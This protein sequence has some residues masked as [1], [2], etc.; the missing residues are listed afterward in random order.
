MKFIYSLVLLLFFHSSHAETYYISTTGNDVTGSGSV[1]NP[2]RSLYKAASAVTV[3]GSI[4]HV[5]AGIYIETQQTI[6]AIGVSIEGDG[7]N[8]VIKSSLTED[9]KELLSLRSEEGTNGNQHISDLKLDGQ[10]LSAFWAIYISGRSNVSVYNCTI[11]DFKDRGVIFNGRND[12]VAEAPSVFATGNK[13]YNNTVSNC[14]AYN[15]ANGV[16]GRGCLNIGGQDGMLIYNNTITQNQRPD[17]YNGYLI[18]YSNDGYL[19]AVKIYDNVLVKI[20]FKGN[21]GGDNGWDF[22]ME[23]WNILGGMEIYGNTVQGAIDLVN[24]SKGTYAYGVSIHDNKISQPALN[25]HYESGIIF[26]VSTESVIIERNV[27]NKIS[28]GILFYAQENS[29]LSDIIIRDNRLEEI[30]RKTGN[31]NNG[32]GININCGTLLGNENHYS[33]SNLLIHNNIITAA[34]DNAPFY[35]IEITGASSVTN[36]KIQKN[37]ISNFTAAAIVANPAYVIDTLTIE[38]NIFLSNGN[39]NNPLYIRGTPGNYTIRN[40][41][42]SN[43]SGKPG[44]NLKQQVLRPLYYEVKSLNPLEVIALLAFIIFFWFARK[45]EIYAFPAGLIYSTIYLFLSYES[46]LPG[47]AFVNICFISICIYGSILW[48]KRDRRNHRV[49]R[50]MSSARKDWLM[51]LLLFGLFFSF[52]FLVLS[53][54][55]K[56]FPQ[57][58]IPVADA[59]I[60][61]AAFT[62]IWLTA[63][64]KVEG[65][66]WWIASNLVAVPAFFVKH[67][68]FFS[69]YYSF[70]LV[71]ATWGLYRW[72]KRRVS[73]RIL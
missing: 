12:N 10:N 71:I 56:Y 13:F 50:I 58:S 41:I 16:Y 39:N 72:K 73:R 64:K 17:G 29:V 7:I 34:S 43:S 11:V 46:S 51:Q 31:G 45:E 40:N 54:G 25:S 35:G 21:Y 24:T 20:P 22:A 61:S 52:S 33:L 57:G 63:K 55:K 32:N 27:I 15:T 69:L 68:F 19:K 66:Y 70:L 14:A 67:Y 2:W 3:S 37:S 48:F 8:S 62:G 28:G 42:K 47:L 18:K 60:Y 26:E 44:L 6:L 38:E 49:V 65:W 23:F 36:V 59:F 30:G 1:S 53:Y 5:N 9:W 4:I